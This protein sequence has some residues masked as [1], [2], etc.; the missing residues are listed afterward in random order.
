ML[1][2]Q[3]RPNGIQRERTAQRLWRNVSPC[4][5]RALV[6]IVKEARRI[7]DEAH[8]AKFSSMSRSPGETLLIQNIDGGVS[9]AAKLE[10]LIEL[11]AIRD[12]T[13]ECL[14]YPAGRAEYDGYAS[15]WKRLEW[16]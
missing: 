11:P 7:N 15:C 10:N 4:L 1:H 16:I 5:L 9:T 3:G 2:N 13:R 12:V 6:S 14:A 8:V